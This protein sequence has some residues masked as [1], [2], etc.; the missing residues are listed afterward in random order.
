M[1]VRGRLLGSK[2][3]D[4]DR[5]LLLSA[6]VLHVALVSLVPR[7]ALSGALVTHSLLTV[8]LVTDGPKRLAASS[9]AAVA[10]LAPGRGPLGTRPAPVSWDV[11]RPVDLVPLGLDVGTTRCKGNQPLLPG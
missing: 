5:R 8:T 10:T 7:D 3:F 6:M 9:T 2:P 4:L 11:G 1:E